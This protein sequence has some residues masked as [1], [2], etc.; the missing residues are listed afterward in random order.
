MYKDSSFIYTDFSLNTAGIKQDAEFLFTV[1]RLQVAQ[2]LSVSFISGPHSQC[3]FSLPVFF[4]VPQ[5]TD[6]T[7]LLRSGS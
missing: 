1:P 2:K 4:Q 5:N 7:L 3:L 6:T